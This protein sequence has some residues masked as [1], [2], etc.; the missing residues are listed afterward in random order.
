MDI[1]WAV[2]ITD[3]TDNNGIYCWYRLP[4]SIYDTICYTH[5]YMF[6][7]TRN[8]SIHNAHAA[9]ILQKLQVHV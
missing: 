1:V 5:V 4:M 6:R 9:W 2:V 3:S 7:S 8:K